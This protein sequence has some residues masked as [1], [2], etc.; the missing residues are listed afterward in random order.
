MVC[1]TF[2]RIHPWK[3]I[4][5]EM[6]ICNINDLLSSLTV[7]N[8]F[9]P[10]NM[11]LAPKAYYNCYTWLPTGN[12]LEA[13]FT[14]LP[15]ATPHHTPPPTTSLSTLALT[16]RYAPTRH[17]CQQKTQTKKYFRPLFQVNERLWEEHNKAAGS[18]M[19]N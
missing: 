10:D 17:Y 9:P 3:K 7:D 19:K 18:T 13:L 11:F 1:V 16:D 12:C 8:V 6:T 14:T 4:M 5:L 15:W 2:F